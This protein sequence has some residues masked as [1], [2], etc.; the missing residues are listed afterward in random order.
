MP[1]FI[2][3][4][5]ETTRSS[6]TGAFLITQARQ[7]DNQVTRAAPWAQMTAR[8]SSVSVAGG[9]RNSPRSTTGQIW[10][11][12]V[13]AARS[14]N[15]LGM[16][17]RES[18]RPL[19]VICVIFFLQGFAYGITS[20]FWLQF[21]HATR[22]KIDV[23]F[24]LHANYFGGYIFGPILIARPIL[25]HAGFKIALVTGLSIFWLGMLTFWPATV[26]IS[27]PAL[28]VASFIAG[29]GISVIET[30]VNLF[31]VLCGPTGHGEMRL[32]IAKGIEAMGRTISSI[33]SDR[34]FFRNVVRAP[35][36]IDVQWVFLVLVIVPPLLAVAYTFMNLYEVSN[37]GLRDHAY[38]RGR[39]TC[40]SVCN[41]RVVWMTLILGDLAQFCSIG[42]QEAFRTNFE[43]FVTFNEPR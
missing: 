6:G 4:T 19:T 17:R 24:A 31:V 42:G 22:S 8:G 29:L 30:T 20:T 10:F 16:S 18:I 13:R 21:Q 28:L 14:Q 32:S 1:W 12:F 38:C 40:A 11:D 25:N 5:G 23:A 35:G 33:L 41:V 36:L 3:R 9:L 43:S 26:L 15:M 7:D 2:Q 27:L 34:V 39:V 37:D